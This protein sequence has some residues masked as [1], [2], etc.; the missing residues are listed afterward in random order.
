M[1]ESSLNNQYPIIISLPHSGTK[2]SK[3]FLN[4]TRGLI[5]VAKIFNVAY[6]L[7]NGFPINQ[8]LVFKNSLFILKLIW[9]NIEERGLSM[10]EIIESSI[11]KL[12]DKKDIEK[13]KVN[14]ESINY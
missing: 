5:N 12:T 4:N 2:Y 13:L 14:F 9:P 7:T 1:I 11:H 10:Q 8:N 6:A 3:F